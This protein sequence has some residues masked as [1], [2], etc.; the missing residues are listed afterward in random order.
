MMLSFHGQR[1]IRDKNIVRLIQ[2]LA[3]DIEWTHM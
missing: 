3:L 1:L 2:D